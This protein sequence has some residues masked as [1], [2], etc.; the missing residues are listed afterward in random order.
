MLPFTRLLVYFFSLLAVVLVGLLEHL[1][2]LFRCFLF[3]LLQQVIFRVS[4]NF[5]MLC[6]DFPFLTCSAN[7][8]PKAAFRSSPVAV[9]MHPPLLNHSLKFDLARNFLH[10]E[11]RWPA[12]VPL[13][14]KFKL[15]PNPIS[16]AS[17][18][19]L[20][21]PNIRH[22]LPLAGLAES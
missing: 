3:S 9:R 13:H 22:Q 11:H 2:L 1:W 20:I 16:M 4:V 14:S 18:G 7:C 6:S 19:R 15:C 5:K 12:V 10:L 17:S 8:F 21:D